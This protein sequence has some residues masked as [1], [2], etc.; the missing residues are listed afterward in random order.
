MFDV[1]FVKVNRKS[2]I[3]ERKGNQSVAK[4]ILAEMLSYKQSCVE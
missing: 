2:V 4:R 3:L 1:K